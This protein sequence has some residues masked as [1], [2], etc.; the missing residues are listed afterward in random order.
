[1][2]KSILRYIH[3]KC[4]ILLSDCSPVLEFLNRFALKS[5][6]SD[7]KKIRPVAVALKR[8]GKWTDTTKQIGA[9]RFLCERT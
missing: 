7:L 4:L 9:F 1:L 5:P 6:I 3:I 2:K 8:E